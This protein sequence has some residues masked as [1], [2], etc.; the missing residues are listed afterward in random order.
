MWG[1]VSE[2]REMGE[3][4]GVGGGE[5]RGGV[6]VGAGHEIRYHCTHFH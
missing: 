3:V 6:C 1:G 2:G 4:R 5:V